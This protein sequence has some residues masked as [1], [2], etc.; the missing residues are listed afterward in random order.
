MHRNCPA[1]KNLRRYGGDP[2]EG[3]FLKKERKKERIHLPFFHQSIN[4]CPFSVSAYYVLDC[5]ALA[6]STLSEEVKKCAGVEGGGGGEG[7]KKQ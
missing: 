3:G 5:L 7:S 4:P 1:L 2:L 6:Y